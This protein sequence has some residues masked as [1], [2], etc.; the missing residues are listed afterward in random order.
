MLLLKFKLFNIC[1]LNEMKVLAGCSGVGKASQT[2]VVDLN[3]DDTVSVFV[4]DKTKLSD[5]DT[6]RFT[7][8]VGIFLRPDN[9]RF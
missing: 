5:S 1:R 3:K 8:F 6:V 2:C 7:H 4:N 9:I